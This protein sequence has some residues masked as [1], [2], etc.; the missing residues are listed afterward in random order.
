MDSEFDVEFSLFISVFKAV[1]SFSYIMLGHSGNN[2]AVL[3]SSFL[4][5]LSAFYGNIT[6][7]LSGRAPTGI[8]IS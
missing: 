6:I 8:R 2:K 3:G 5:R 4:K 1:I 7:S